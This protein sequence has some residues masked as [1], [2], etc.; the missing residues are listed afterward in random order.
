MFLKLKNVEDM[1]VDGLMMLVSINRLGVI[2]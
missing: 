1:R 2:A